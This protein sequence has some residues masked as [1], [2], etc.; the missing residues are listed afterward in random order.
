M[1]LPSLAYSSL[2]DPLGTNGTVP[3]GI[4]VSG[5][6]VGN[7]VDSNDVLHGFLYSNGTYTSITD[8]SA[9]TTAG[10]Q[11]FGT[12]AHSVNDSDQIVGYYVDGTTNGVHG[13]LYSGGTNGT[14]TT[15]DDP[16]ADKGG[17]IGTVPRGIND[18]G[19]IVGYYIT[20]GSWKGFLYSGG[21]NGTY[22]NLPDD[23]SA[24]GGPGVAPLAINDLG[25]IVGYTTTATATRRPSCTVTA[26]TLPL[27]SRCKRHRCRWRRHDCI[28]HQRRRPGRRLVF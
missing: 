1:V 11:G 7:Y 10:F 6:I 2:N 8:P 16:L 9:R 15:L 13:F 14:Y 22:T 5:E 21:S 24:V 27:S 17:G 20:G 26:F 3:F 12:Y 23:P 18:L 4:N 25:Q 19:Q 28:R